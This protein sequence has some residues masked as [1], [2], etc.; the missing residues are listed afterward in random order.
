M[1]TY[2]D[3]DGNAALAAIKS[4]VARAFPGTLTPASLATTSQPAT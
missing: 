2:P 3:N 4:I 1:T